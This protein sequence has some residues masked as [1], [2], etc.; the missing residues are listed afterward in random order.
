VFD[1][2]YA[3]RIKVD[4]F[5]VNCAVIPAGKVNGHVPVD[6]SGKNESVVVIHVFPHQI[7]PAW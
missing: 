4:R 5:K 6:G 2:E 3:M 7:H 1:V